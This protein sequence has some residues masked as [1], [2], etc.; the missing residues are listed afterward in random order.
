MV[1]FN[2]SY[3]TWEKLSK[4]DCYNGYRVLMNRFIKGNRFFAYAHIYELEGKRFASV[5]YRM[6]GNKLPNNFFYKDNFEES[7]IVSEAVEHAT[8]KANL[9]LW[10]F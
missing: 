10:R 5:H 6:N 9:I 4:L 2:W 1:K 3:E 7:G 8:D